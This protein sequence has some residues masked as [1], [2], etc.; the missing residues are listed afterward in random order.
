MQLVELVERVCHAA[1]TSYLNFFPPTSALRIALHFVFG[2]DNS[3]AESDAALNAEFS[4][5]PCTATAT[6]KHSLTSGEL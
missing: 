1:D 6:S 4:S 2:Q 3:G 5:S